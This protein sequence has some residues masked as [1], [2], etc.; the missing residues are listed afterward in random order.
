[1]PRTVRIIILCNSPLNECPKC[2]ANDIASPFVSPAD[3]IYAAPVRSALSALILRLC[4]TCERQHVAGRDGAGPTSHL[5][6]NR[7]DSGSIPATSTN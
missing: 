6:A 4:W 5:L 3:P 2:P 1:M 7:V